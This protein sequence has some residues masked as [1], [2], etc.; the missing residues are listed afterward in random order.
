MSIARSCP[1]SEEKDN[2]KFET[3]Y[4][5][6]RLNKCST[7]DRIGEKLMPEYIKRMLEEQKEL[8]YRI[9]KL[10]AFQNESNEVYK[11]DVTEKEKKLLQ[12]QYFA[13]CLYSSTLLERILLHTSLG[14][15]T[16]EE[17]EAFLDRKVEN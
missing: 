11:N 3:Y 2:C 6:P 9:Q 14:H 5:H 8:S 4:G 15:V 17:V 13:M 10:Y 7:C 1:H 16:T 12:N